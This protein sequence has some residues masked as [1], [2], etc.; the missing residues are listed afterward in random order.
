MFK[1]WHK[2]DL[3]SPISSLIP[4]SSP[5]TS[6]ILC[7]SL[8]E[9][10]LEEEIANYQN[11]FLPFYPESTLS[12][13]L[14]PNSTNTCLIIITNNLHIAKFI[15]CLNFIGAVSCGL[16]PSG[17][18]PPWLQGCPVLVDFLSLNSSFL[19]SSSSSSP[20]ES[21]VHPGHRTSLSSGLSDFTLTPHMPVTQQQLGSF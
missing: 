12:R 13:F 2:Y 8:Q 1:L 4:P 18:I 21:S 11:V 14:L 17:N 16:L 5:D 20:T 9:I 6:P 15:F 10:S 7:F 19:P 3:I